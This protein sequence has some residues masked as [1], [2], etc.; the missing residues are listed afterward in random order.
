[1]CGRFTSTT[2]AGD[3]AA[4]FDADASDIVELG[5]DFN[6]T[7]TSE[8][9]IVRM[10]DGHRV[11]DVVRW[12]L[13]P[14]W[15]ESP[16][17]GSRLINARSETASTKPSFR[18]AFRRRRCL[19]PIDGFYE[20]AVVAGQRR[21]QPY[22]LH[23]R[24]DRPLAVA[25]LWES[26]RPTDGPDGSVLRT[27]TILTG[28]PNAVAAP[29]HNRMPVILAPDEWSIWLDPTEDDADL[30]QSLLDPAPD[31]VLEAWPV[32][33]AVNDLHRHDRGLVDPVDPGPAGDAGVQDSLF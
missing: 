13:V 3:L 16:A 4:Y 5:E 7:P 29:I 25:G 1:M 24:D 22:H 18:S 19:V 20:W 14:R 26:W 10:D 11:L 21:K 33:L 30:L 12:G 2:S 9:Y 8:C 31:D 17:I 32:S 23:A 15:A 28:P 6:V 27:C